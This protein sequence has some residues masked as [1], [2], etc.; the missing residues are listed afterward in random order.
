[1]VERTPVDD[2]SGYSR[3][4]AWIDKAEYRFQKIKYFD[5]RGDLL[6]TLT[7]NGYDQY[8]GR[9]W[10]PSEMDMQNHQTGKG[11][12]LLWHRYEFRTGLEGNDF[13]RTALRRS[14]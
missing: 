10:R 3:Q 5:R 11:T 14:R 12:L 4:V 2:D 13:T 9:F 8:L 6:K 1:M 7:I